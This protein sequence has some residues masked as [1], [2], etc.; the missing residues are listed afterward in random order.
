VPTLRVLLGQ[1]LGVRVLALALAILGQ[2]KEAE[3]RAPTGPKA[4]GAQARFEQAC[5]AADGSLR[6]AT[7]C[8]N[9]KGHPDD[10][11]SWPYNR[12]LDRLD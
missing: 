8:Q 5:F 9:R 7:A 11:L 2:P 4:I 6:G 12:V 3:R 10:S 1:N